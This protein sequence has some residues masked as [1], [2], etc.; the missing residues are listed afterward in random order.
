MDKPLPRFTTKSTKDEILKAYNEL[1][2]RFQERTSSLSEKKAETMRKASDEAV[3]EKVAG[4][5]VDSII[6]GMADLSLH[7]GKAL[8]D[9][10]SQLT[11]ETNKLTELQQAIAIETRALEELHD[12]RLAAD[13]LALLIQD[14][15]DKKAAFEKELEESETRFDAEMAAKRLDWKKEQEAYVMVQKEND[16]R[17]KKERERE[18]EEYEYNLA[19]TRKKDKDNYE[20]EKAALTK[21]LAEVKEIQEKALTAREAAVAAQE[22]ELAELRK[23]VNV[24]PAE[25][26]AA[27]EKAEKEA[28]VRAENRA[29]MEAQLLG[30]AIEGDKRVAEL[31]IKGL[32]ETVAKQLVQVEALTRQLNDANAQVQAIAVKAIEGASGAKALSAINEIAIEQAKNLRSKM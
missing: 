11:S 25:L 28:M 1:L 4:Y 26:A 14:H 20:A 30:K 32:E 12:I 5:T 13:S 9:L 22:S 24:F 8:T 23:K 18:K 2:S 21:R 16:A 29:K 19:L 31:K 3:L 7:L 27:V 17:L 10:A 6:K 15:E